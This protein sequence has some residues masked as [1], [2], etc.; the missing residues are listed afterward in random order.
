MEPTIDWGVFVPVLVL[1]V[2]AIALAVWMAVTAWRERG[3]FNRLREC[4]E[5]RTSI[6]GRCVALEDR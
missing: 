3:Q 4:S 6:R 1:T 2:G 5:I